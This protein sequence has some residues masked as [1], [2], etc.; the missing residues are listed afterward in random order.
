MNKLLIAG[1]LGF[2][3]SA[4][5][6][7]SAW[8]PE[9]RKLVVTPSYVYHT[10]DEYWQGNRTTSLGGDSWQH[11]AL[12]SFDYGLTDDTALDLSMGWVWRDSDAN[13]GSD[14]GLSDAS[15]GI[16]RRFIDEA[17]FDFWWLPSLALR[18]GGTIPGTYD[19][20]FPL[21]TL[22]GAYGAEVSLLG[23][24]PILPGFGWY[25]EVGYRYRY[26]VPDDF[27]GAAGLFVSWKF[28]S[29]TAGYRFTEGLSGPDIGEPGF[30]F[31]EVKEVSQNVEASLGFN[32]AG[33]RSYQFFYAH[34][35]EGRNT[36]QRNIFGAAVSLTW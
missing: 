4:S 13:F 21:S 31:P 8:L 28:L 5:A 15:F 14:N 9:A 26:D 12:L 24:K 11:A 20:D 6:Q 30:T 33:G 3:V 1:G 25:G 23:G 16:R 22:D 17:N 10:F 19:E 2:A 29:L 18:A 7:H 27:F 34:T 32:D 35:F 36:G